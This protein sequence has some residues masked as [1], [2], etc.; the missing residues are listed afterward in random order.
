LSKK[1]KPAKTPQQQAIAARREVAVAYHHS[2][3]LP[4]PLTFEKYEM[5]LP[6]SA[7]RILRMAEEQSEHRR[8]LEDIVIRSRS[9]DSFL[10]VIFAFLLG[11]AVIISGTIVIIK[12]YQVSGTLLSGAGLVGLVAVFIYGT[13]SAKK[14]RENKNF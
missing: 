1:D 6:G 8:K 14:E 3:P 5:I 10:G 4:D 12:G 13:R 7:E 9:R 11:L 2:G